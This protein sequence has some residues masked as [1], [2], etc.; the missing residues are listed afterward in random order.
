MKKIILLLFALVFQTLN[1]E[2]SEYHPLLQDGKK[3][4]YYEWWDLDC[5]REDMFLH[6]W[7]DGDTIVESTVCK[8]LYADRRSL[9]EAAHLEAC[10]YEDN[11]QVFRI[12][13]ISHGRQ[14]LYDFGA[15]VGDVFYVGDNE[16]QQEH[17][18]TDMVRVKSMGNVFRRILLEYRDDYGYS[19][20]SLWTE[21]VGSSIYLLEPFARGV[22]GD[23]RHLVTCE[24]NDVVI[25]DCREEK[26]VS[27]QDGL[28]YHPF[29]KEGKVWKCQST[30]ITSEENADYVASYT[31]TTVYGLRLQGDTVVNGLAYKRMYKDVEYVDRTLRWASSEDAET[32]QH[33]EGGTT[34]CKELWR[35]QDQKVYVYHPSRGE[36]QLL[37]DFSL[38]PGETAVVGG[39]PTTVKQTD[40]LEASSGLEF[41]RFRVLIYGEDDGW[42]RVWVE[43]I[44]HPAGPMQVWGA[45]VNDGSTHTLLSV[46]E[47][48]ECVF[49]QED[50][51]A[52]SSD[53]T[54]AIATPQPSSPRQSSSV[55]DLQGRKAGGCPAK[56]LY[57][58]NGKKYVL[59]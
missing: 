55:Y 1:A 46:Y 31:Q 23:Y 6:C 5:S 13:T 21:G 17:H 9:G 44:G 43:G 32:H 12:D 39:I 16:G 29:L 28:A 59:K 48:G 3:W 41:R 8:K 53:I 22:A 56:G 57:I 36:E 30:E 24:V 10:L 49:T 35:E 14:L 26:L 4:T 33:W 45:E 2:K 25:F 7:I 50:F 52:P 27:A 40:A 20:E 47:D 19:L 18:V 15:E 37:Y 54:D 11:K 42:D 58:R 51:N 34:R 38:T